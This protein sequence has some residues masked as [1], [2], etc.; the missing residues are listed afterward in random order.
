M[1]AQRQP[2]QLDLDTKLEN[3]CSNLHL[4]HA[5][6]QPCP[7]ANTTA[8]ALAPVSHAASAAAGASKATGVRLKPG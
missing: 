5:F 7:T 1:S 8:S 6:R 4:K 3:E 2:S